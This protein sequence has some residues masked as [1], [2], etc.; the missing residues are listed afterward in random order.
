MVGLILTLLIESPVMVLQK[1]LIAKLTGMGRFKAPQVNGGGNGTVWAPP[2]Y[3]PVPNGVNGF[4]NNNHHENNNNGH[5][6]VT[7]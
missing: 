6:L 2:V 1:E 3:T 4:N 7:G 5:I